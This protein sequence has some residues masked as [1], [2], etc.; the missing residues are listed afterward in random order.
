MA[1]YLDELAARLKAMG[2][3][4]VYEDGGYYWV[5]K[6]DYKPSDRIAL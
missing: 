2:A 3:H 5:L 6:P 1:G 4:R